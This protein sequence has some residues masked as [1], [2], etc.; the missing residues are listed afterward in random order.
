MYRVIITSFVAMLPLISPS[1]AAVDPGALWVDGQNKHSPFM[2]IYGDSRPPIGHIRFCRTHAA[3]CRPHAQRFGRVSLSPDRW[4]E[5]V[6]VNSL[7]NRIIKPVSDQE[8]YGEVERWAYPESRGDCEDYALLKQRM[9]KQRG[10]PASALLITVV[11]DEKG[12][13]HAIL[14]ARTSSGDFVLDNKRPKVLAWNAVPYRYYKRQSYRNPGLWVSLK[15]AR[16]VWR[17][18]SFSRSVAQKA[19]NARTK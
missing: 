10:W 13:G 15:P 5:L 12:Q 7:V 18:P 3:E 14:T 4:R 19:R 6:A 11:T 9:L 17:S 2:R 16:E 1:R 8:L